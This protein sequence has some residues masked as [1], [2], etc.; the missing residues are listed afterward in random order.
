VK[1]IYEPGGKAAALLRAMREDPK[2]A[3]SFP[4]AAEIMGGHAKNVGAATLKCVK[5]GL[6]HRHVW[7][8]RVYLSADADA[9]MPERK[10]T[11]TASWVPDPDDPRI[12]KVVPGWKPPQMVCVRAQ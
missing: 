8:G 11:T 10:P 12:S 4:E 1:E 5:S 2:R 9:R 6:I 7:D 3:F